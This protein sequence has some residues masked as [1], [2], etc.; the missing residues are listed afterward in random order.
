MKFAYLIEPPFNFRDKDGVVVGCDIELA[1][2]VLSEL[3]RSPI[4]FVESEFAELLPGVGA[5][6]WQMTTGLFGTD[7]RRE[8]ASFSRP[9]WALSD[10][11]LVRE[12]NP[13]RLHGYRSIAENLDCILAVIRDQFQHRS[14]M[15]FGIPE[16]R[17]AIFE[18]YSAA[19]I[20]VRDGRVDAYASVGRAHSGFVQRNPGWALDVVTVP[21]L[22]K[23]PAF[24]S[25]AFGRADAE[26]RHAVDE[27]LVRYVGTPAHRKMMS[28]YGFF[29]H[30]IDLLIS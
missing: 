23:A 3:G 19:A 28:R 8:F 17:I 12:G 1:E 25:F 16:D 2:Y 22:E 9:I 5:G 4:E 6:R 14:A 13:L 24:G 20:A 18:T 15:D 10:G 21:L 27:V 26:L 7:E 11:L 29:D 30:E